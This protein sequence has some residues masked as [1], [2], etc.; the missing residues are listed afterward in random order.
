MED[1]IFPPEF[2]ALIKAPS[3]RRAFVS[4]IISPNPSSCKN[5]GGLGSMA[6]YIATT[7]PLTNC[8][9]RSKLIVHF[10]EDRFWL[11]KHYEFDCPVCHSLALPYRGTQSVFE[12]D[13]Q[14]SEQIALL[15]E[16]WAVKDV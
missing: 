4:E 8:P 6:V 5:C 1:K 9:D 7:G 16:D 2:D 12:R 11:G 14:V 3:V 13:K 10:A 15:A